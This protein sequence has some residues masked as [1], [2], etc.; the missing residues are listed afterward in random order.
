MCF[1]G[2]L[3]FG[4]PF[5]VNCYPRAEG[6]ISSRYARATTG[7][8]NGV[9]FTGT[10]SPL[11]IACRYHSA[12]VDI[13][14]R[15]PLAACTFFRPRPRRASVAVLARVACVPPARASSACRCAGKRA[16]LLHRE[17]SEQGVRAACS[18]TFSGGSPGGRV[19]SHHAGSSD[20]AR[21]EARAAGRTTSISGSST[22]LLKLNDTKRIVAPLSAPTRA[23]R[24]RDLCHK[25]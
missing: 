21:Q 14:F 20:T 11:A 12:Y 18:P 5:V 7:T 19:P 1:P 17:A 16:I 3:F 25:P 23:R 2:I 9:K 4:T 6:A 22:S 24:N 10:T 13:M 8:G 15:V